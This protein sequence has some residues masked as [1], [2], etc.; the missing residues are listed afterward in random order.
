MPVSYA[1][2]SDRTTVPRWIKHFE[3]QALSGTSSRSLFNRRL[4]V[5]EKVPIES[6]PKE[7][8]EINLPPI[9]SPVQQSVEQAKEEIKRE[10]AEPEGKELNQ[11][12]KSQVAK[13]I[14]PVQTDT[15]TP[16]RTL[17]SQ[18]KRS[19]KRKFKDIFSG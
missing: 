15:P 13:L 8:V 18:Q 5:I 3:I 7:A 19:R 12:F 17:F 6:S 2:N 4:I 9:V 14:S 11:K 16:P 1:V 10:V